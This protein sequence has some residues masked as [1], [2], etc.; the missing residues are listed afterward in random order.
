MD[1]LY[2]FNFSDHNDSMHIQVVSWRDPKNPRAGGAETCLMEIS[3]AMQKKYSVSVAWFAPEFLGCSQS[4]TFQNVEITRKGSAV[5]LAWNAFWRFRS[6]K[7]DSRTIYLEDY[8]GMSLGLSIYKKRSVILVHEVASLIWYSMWKFPISSFG[9]YLEK[10][11]LFILRKSNFIAVSSSTKEELVQNRVDKT[12]ILQ[13]SEASTLIPVLEG[14]PKS[15]RVPRFLIL[16]R[17]CAM[18][19]IHLALRAFQVVKRKFP[20]MQLCIAGSADPVTMK[21]LVKLVGELNLVGS[22]SFLGFV[23]EKE[24]IE[25]LRNSLALLS[26]SEKEGFGL[27]VLESNSQGT[28]VITFD[29]QG[30]RDTVKNSRNGYLVPNGDL[31]A[32]ASKMEHLCQMD[33]EIYHSLVKTCLQELENYSW[34]RTADILYEHFQKIISDPKSEQ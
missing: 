28:P 7:I 8:H 20:H 14:K 33:N 11:F 5:G 15:Q 22:V 31:V 16:G 2:L 9:Y 24:K 4:E 10:C 34:Q 3:K 21:N 26:C 32:F 19:R 12:K 30:F 1:S 18:K 27:V 13:I 6:N 29:V 25:L 23:A 17:V